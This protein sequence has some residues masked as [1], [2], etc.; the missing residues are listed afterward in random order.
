[1][2]RLFLAQLAGVFLILSVAAWFIFNSVPAVQA[3]QTCG[4]ASYYGTESGNRTANGEHFD[5]RSMTAASRTLPFGTRL[6]V[7]N[8]QNGKSVQV[9]INDRGP[10]VKGR[11]LDL[12]KTAA[13]RIGLVSA[14]VGR[15]CLERVR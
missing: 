10:Y 14:G 9:R 1:M 3:A 2:I 5:G 11:I 12:S 4:L 8:V 6:I 15:V 7:R 13:S